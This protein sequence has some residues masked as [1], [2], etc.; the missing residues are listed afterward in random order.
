MWKNTSCRQ[1]INK[2]LT[3]VCL[4]LLAGRAASV[5]IGDIPPDYLGKSNNGNEVHVSD[6]VGRITIVSFWA[7]WCPPCLKELPVLNAIQNNG[8]LERIQVIA[9]NL[10]ESKKQFR[11]ALRAFA[12]FNIAFVHDQRGSVARKYGVQGI[13]H[14]LIID[15]DGRVA[16]Q[17]FGY[18]E[19]A[20]EGIVSEINKLLVKNEMFEEE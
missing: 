9:V 17:H 11:K 1:T 19:T 20:L 16:Y 7:T 4:I 5:E 2:A 13:P 12:E 18:D 8:G 3:I 10:K 14:I 15:V 6:S